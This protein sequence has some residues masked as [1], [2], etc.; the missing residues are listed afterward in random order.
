MTR[1]PEFDDFHFYETHVFD[2]DAYVKEVVSRI[3]DRLEAEIVAALRERGW[4]VDKPQEG[5]SAEDRW[6]RIRNAVMGQ[7]ADTGFDYETR[8]R[9]AE[10]GAREVFSSVESEKGKVS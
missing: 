10:D 2:V 3:D 9:I 1:G 5:M 6:W 7:I 8:S 4:I